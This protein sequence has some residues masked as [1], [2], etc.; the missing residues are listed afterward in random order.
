MSIG[1]NLGDDRMGNEDDA[2]EISRL[3]SQ[4]EDQKAEIASIALE[5]QRWKTEHRLLQQ[6]LVLEQKFL[7][8]ARKDRDKYKVGLEEI[9]SAY[10]NPD[11]EFVEGVLSCKYLKNIAE[12]ALKR[13]LLI[14]KEEI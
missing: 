14:K 6:S 2:W 7:S 3:Q 5:C 11:P 4:L 10:N 8:D 9:V 13:P 1:I 12:E